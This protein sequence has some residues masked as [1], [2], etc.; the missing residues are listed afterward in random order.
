LVKGIA[1]ARQEGLSQLD[2]RFP[3]GLF[4]KHDPKGLV[5]EHASQVSSYWPYAHDNF[6]EEVFTENAQDW[7]DVVQR[8]VE[9]KMTKFKAMSI[10]E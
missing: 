7:D 8:M 2:F 9:P 4:R 1:Q 6:E 10:V 3:T 5:L